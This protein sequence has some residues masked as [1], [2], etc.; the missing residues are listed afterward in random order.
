MNF[1]QNS[2][3]FS[4]FIAWF[5]IVRL[6]AAGE[7]KNLTPKSPICTGEV[8]GTSAKVMGMT[9]A[10]ANE[11]EKVTGSVLSPNMT[12]TLELR[13]PSGGNMK[14][15]PVSEAWLQV[16]PCVPFFIFPLVQSC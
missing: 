2:L 15:S 12:S 7:G 3:F 10:T 1:R 13:N 14:T 6:T 11:A 5:C 8:N 9:V 4:C 16:L